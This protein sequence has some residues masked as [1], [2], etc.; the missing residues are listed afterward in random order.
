MG[1][2]HA[3]A[4]KPTALLPTGRPNPTPGFPRLTDSYLTAGLDANAS[5]RLPPGHPIAGALLSSQLVLHPQVSFPLAQGHYP[6]HHLPI[7]LLSSHHPILP[8]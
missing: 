6:N 4:Y 1:L 8:T 3:V 7:T 5:A 2:D